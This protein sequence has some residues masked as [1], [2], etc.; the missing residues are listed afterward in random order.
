MKLHNCKYVVAKGTTGRF[1][2][3]DLLAHPEVNELYCLWNCG[4]YSN[5]FQVF[6]SLLVLLRH[7]I[8]PERIDYSLG[9]RHFKKDPNQDIYLDFHKINEKIDLDLFVDISLPDSNKC[10]FDLYRFD[11]YNKIRDRFFGP[12]DL[13]AERKNI[14]INKYKFDPQKTISVLYRGTDKST[15][16]T[17]GSPTEY[18]KVVKNILKDN[19][20]FK[21]LLQTDQTQVIQYFYDQLGDILITFEETPSTTSNRVIW[22]LMEQSD[23]DSIDWS[24]WFDAALRCVADCKYLV[25]HTGNVAFFAN[26]YR[27]N[28]N[29][30]H[31]FNENG[32]LVK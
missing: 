28:I 21:V 8:I 17:L 15:E 18:L 20:N 30:V 16:L 22:S 6:N 4:F 32:V 26:L 2:G 31:Q 24:Q 14:L 12:S 23:K 5:E 10:Q 9:Y 13:I 3:C 29:G 11:I 7:G 27:G 19:P 25:N 1:A